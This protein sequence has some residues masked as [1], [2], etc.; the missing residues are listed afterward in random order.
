MI[1]RSIAISFVLYH[2]TN[3]RRRRW[4]ILSTIS[5]G[6]LSQRYIPKVGGLCLLICVHP[7]VI[8]N[9]TIVQLTCEIISF[10]LCYFG[11]SDCNRVRCLR[12]TFT[13]YTTQSAAERLPMAS[14]FIP[15]DARRTCFAEL[16][17][18]NERQISVRWGRRGN[19]E[20]RKLTKFKDSL[21]VE[22]S[23]KLIAHKQC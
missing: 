12:H 21:L 4:P 9:R 20:N 2:L 19:V 10:R 6:R 16:L 1:S 5:A 17:T 22:K 13:E 8:F 7:C 3:F 14:L 23:G 15:D 18:C 11:W